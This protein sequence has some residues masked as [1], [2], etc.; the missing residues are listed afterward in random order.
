[1]SNPCHALTGLYAA[2]LVERFEKY[3]CT[4]DVFV[5]DLAPAARR[6]VHNLSSGGIGALLVRRRIRI[7]DSPQKNQDRISRAARPT[8]RS[9][10]Q[11]SQDRASFNHIYHVPILAVGHPRCGTG[12]AASL[13]QQFG[14]DVGHERAGRDGL[15]SWMFRRR[16][17]RKSVGRRR[18]SRGRARHRKPVGRVGGCINAE[19]NGIYRCIAGIAAASGQ[20]LQVVVVREAG[21]HAMIRDAAATATARRDRRPRARSRKR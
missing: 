7:P 6:G 8:R 21:Q 20:V 2:A 9:K 13:L 17:R 14:L 3:N 10:G 18:H 16:G 12:Y 5:H 19:S 15:S 4:S 1:M 11:R